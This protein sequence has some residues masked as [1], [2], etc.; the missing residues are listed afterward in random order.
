ME[1]SLRRLQ[2]LTKENVEASSG[3]MPPLN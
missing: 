1:E 2:A 3:G